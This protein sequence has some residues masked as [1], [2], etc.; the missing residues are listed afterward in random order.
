MIILVTRYTKDGDFP[1]STMD[2]TTAG[3]EAFADLLGVPADTLTEVYPLR[4]KHAERFQQLTGI[5]LDL[6]KYDYFLEPGAD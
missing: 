3:A 1:D 5:P 2:V 4:Q 6:E